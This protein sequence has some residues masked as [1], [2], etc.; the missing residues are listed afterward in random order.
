[1]AFHIYNF[2]CKSSALQQYA[3]KEGLIPEKGDQ[4]QDFN[5]PRQLHKQFADKEKGAACW[6]NF[7]EKATTATTKASQSLNF[8]EDSDEWYMG[9]KH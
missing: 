9:K 5:W 4:W 2:G 8:L 3:D 7:L 6:Q 1:M